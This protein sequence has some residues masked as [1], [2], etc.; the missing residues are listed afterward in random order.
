MQDTL[1]LCC[2]SAADT[3]F[4]LKE[5]VLED[6]LLVPWPPRWLCQYICSVAAD[7]PA[8][9]KLSKWLLHSSFLR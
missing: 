5:Y 6:S 4:Q 2:S 3:G 8:W 7:L 1:L 9:R